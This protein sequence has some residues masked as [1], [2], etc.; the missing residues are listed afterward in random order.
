MR[1]P[2]ST[3]ATSGRRPRGSR[4]DPSGRTLDAVV[5]SGSG[6]RGKS[7]ALGAKAASFP[8]AGTQVSEAFRRALAALIL[9]AVIILPLVFVPGIDDEYALPKAVALRLL[10]IVG[11]TLFLGYVAS[12]GSL[13]RN[14]DI[15]LDAPLACFVGLLVAAS[16]L[17]VDPGQSLAGEPYQFQGLIT[18]LVYIGA[19]FAARLSLGTPSGVWSILL[20]IT[21]T[22]AVV[23]IYAIAQQLGFDPFW[24][25]P[26]DPRAISS[27]GQANDLAAYLDLV[28]VATLGLW[29]GSGRNERVVL[30]AI[31]VVTIVALGL[32]FSRG[33]YLALGAVVLIWI[34][35]GVRSAATRR[36]SAIVLLAAGAMLALVIVTPATRG[37]I[38]RVVD[39]A[40]ATTDLGE[41]SIRMHLDLW[42]VGTQVALEHPVL[43]TGPETFPIV[44]RPYLDVLPADRA[45]NLA[46][47]RAESPHNELIGL[48]AEVGV[49]AVVVYVVF[50]VMC[51]FIVVRGSR[52]APN[53]VRKSIAFVVLAALATHVITTFFMTP[54]I[55]TSALFWVTIGAGLAATQPVDASTQPARVQPT[56][57]RRAR[58]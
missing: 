57:G 41:G 40:M 25:G 32:T 13:T 50:L 14:A 56:R 5:G 20:A 21:G 24:S 23:A 18:G 10:A 47:F 17:S 42:R 1:Q 16:V 7:N 8:T 11:V 51:A 33:G 12:G 49:P 48:A 31:L 52:D 2:A 46:K 19:F 22:G 34:L 26:P 9:G 44:F 28:V 37:T 15:R 35:P 6:A 3:R 30:A 53:R 45:Q 54:E 4:Q 27:V 55:S 58:R 29:T 38:E 43:G 36:R 39:R